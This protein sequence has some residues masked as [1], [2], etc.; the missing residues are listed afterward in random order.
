MKKNWKARLER[1]MADQKDDL[2][3][4]ELLGIDCLFV[5]EGIT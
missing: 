4:W 2:L 1:L 3:T 5:D